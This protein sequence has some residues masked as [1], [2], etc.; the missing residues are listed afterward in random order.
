MT[1]NSLNF[2]AIKNGEMKKKKKDDS[3][4]KPEGEKIYGD[5]VYSPDEDIYAQAKK[6]SIRNEEEPPWSE[7]LDVPGSDLDDKDERIG[8]ED[9]ENNYYSIGGDDHN[10]LE[11]EKE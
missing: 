11:E 8:E 6:E 3:H 1:I 10:D 4:Q 5:A 9:E 2:D 7:G